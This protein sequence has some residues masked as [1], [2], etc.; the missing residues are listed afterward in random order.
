LKKCLKALLSGSLPPESLADVCNSYDIIGDIAIIRSTA[1][2][3]KFGENVA[4]AIIK[5]HRNV[6]TVL[7]Q[8]S[9]VDGDFRLRGLAYI[10]GEKRTKTVHVE[11]GCRFLVDVERCYF[12]PRLSYE[13]KRIADQVMDDETVVNMFAGIGCFSI[14]IATRLSTGRVYSIDINPTAVQFMRENIRINNV[15]GKIIPILGD[16]KDIIQARLCH[17]A[18]RVL[19]PLPERALAYLP[20]A[21]RALKTSGGWLHYYDFERA[22][23]INPVEK[24]RVKM[25]EKLESLGVKFAVPFGRVVRS[26][27]PNWCQVVLDIC[28]KP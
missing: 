16:S 4:E 7:A 17:L 12:S 10:A 27:G 2:P 8:T 13:R 11:S 1:L 28:I 9:P 15:F 25:S 23:S 19:M 22:R 26:T 3:R 14:L 21:V 18:D 24:V 5:T 20:Y 6:K